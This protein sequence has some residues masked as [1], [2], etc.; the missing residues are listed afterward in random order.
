M[1]K[2]YDL[3][4]SNRDKSKGDLSYYSTTVRKALQEQHTKNECHNPPPPTPYILTHKKGCAVYKF[5]P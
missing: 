5:S 1:G 4:P 2:T 3:T